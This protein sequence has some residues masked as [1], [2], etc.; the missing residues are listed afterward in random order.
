MY[1]SARSK[2]G[3][4]NAYI[5][6]ERGSP[7]RSD[8]YVLETGEHL[9]LPAVGDGRADAIER[10]DHR[11]SLNVDLFRRLTKRGGVRVQVALVIAEESVVWL[12]QR[13]RD[14]ET[15]DR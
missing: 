12:R 11:A 10:L 7:G 13:L 6:T 4:Q 3:T 2:P 14:L 1:T 8:V 9:A 5:L 15:E